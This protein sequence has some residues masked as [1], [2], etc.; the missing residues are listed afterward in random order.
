MDWFDLFKNDRNELAQEGYSAALGIIERIQ[1]M[2]EQMLEHAEEIADGLVGAGLNRKDARDTA[3]RLLSPMLKDLDEREKALKKD[4]E[5][6]M[7]EGMKE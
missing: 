5:F 2:R 6:Y 7:K 1:Q 3:K 4:L